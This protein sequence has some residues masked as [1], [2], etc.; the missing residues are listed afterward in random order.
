MSWYLTWR[1]LHLLGAFGF[2]AAHGATAT[3][4]FKLRSER[5]PIRIRTMLDLSR[6]TRGF[7]YAS[8]LVMVGAGT[9]LGFLMNWWHSLWLWTSIALLTVLFVAAFPLALPYF[10][11]IRKAVDQEPPDPERVAALVRSPRGL[12]LAWVETLGIVA[13]IYLM[14]NKPF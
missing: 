4:T 9:V 7:M 5:D 11:A 1:L 3:V 2:I 6:A 13:I 10:R 12:V 14:V 8:F